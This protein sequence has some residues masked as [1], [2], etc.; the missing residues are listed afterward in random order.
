MLGRGNACWSVYSDQLERES[1]QISSS[2][3]ELLKHFNCFGISLPRFD[4]VCLETAG[5]R[6]SHPS[7]MTLVSLYDARAIR[8]SRH[9]AA[10]ATDSYF[11]SSSR[12]DMLGRFLTNV[13]NVVTQCRCLPEGVGNNFAPTRFLREPRAAGNRIPLP[14]YR[15]CLRLGL[16][17]AG[18]EPS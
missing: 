7:S 8:P 2:Q 14:H 17:S 5:A 13:V 1:S 4:L 12:M 9:H 10:R 11:A 16:A 18:T 6:V 3:N 15:Q